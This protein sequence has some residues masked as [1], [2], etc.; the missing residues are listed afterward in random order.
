MSEQRENEEEECRL[1]DNRIDFSLN[2]GMNLRG[3][4]GRGLVGGKAT[5][6]SIFLRAPS[7]P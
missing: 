6:P 5:P 4:E 7:A 1:T 2:V 3:R